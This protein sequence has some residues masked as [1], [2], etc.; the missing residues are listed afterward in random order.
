[1]TGVTLRKATADDAEAIGA[2]HVASWR[3]TY[4]GILPDQMLAGLSVGERAAMWRSILAA[5][6]SVGCIAVLVAEDGGDMIGFGACGEQRD[7]ALIDA[8]FSGQFGAIY[9][10]RTYHKRGIGTA[11]IT[12]M[13]KELSAAGHAAASLWVLRGN[14]PARAFYNRLGGIVIGEKVEEQVGVL[15]TEDAYGW[16]D[17]SRLVG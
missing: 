2:L 17:L 5:P 8:G 11:L 9:V 12:A 7:Q 15:L 1:M 16:R 14:E 4:A 10:L 6:D 13:A 3:E